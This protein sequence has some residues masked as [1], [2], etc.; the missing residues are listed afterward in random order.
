[1]GIVIAAKVGN[2]YFYEKAKLWGGTGDQLGVQDKL[3]LE[4][5]YK[6]AAA[7]AGAA[8]MIELPGTP[9]KGYKEESARAM[10]FG[11]FYS[12]INSNSYKF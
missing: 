10:E 5:V 1:M 8:E 2:P 3:E 7:E 4:Q 11:V 9:V 6:A 12:G